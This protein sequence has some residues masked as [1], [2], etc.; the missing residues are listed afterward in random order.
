MN[1][2]VVT[3]IWTKTKFTY[4]TYSRSSHELFSSQ[5]RKVYEIL[6]LKATNKEND[7]E[8]K[9]YRVDV[10]SRLSQPYVKQEKQLAKIKKMLA[11]EEYTAAMNDVTTKE[12][13]IEALTA[14]YNE[15]EEHYE[16]VLKR[17]RSSE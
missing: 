9:A 8:Y 7:V 10:K 4:H 5:A 15:L 17:L 12:A 1:S 13:R 3:S 11:Q 14:Q 6:R 2:I 16:M